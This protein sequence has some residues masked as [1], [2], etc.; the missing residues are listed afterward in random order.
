VKIFVFAVNS[1]KHFSTLCARF[2]LELEEEN[3]WKFRGNLCRLQPFA[4][5]VMLKPSFDFFKKPL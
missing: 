4:A 3:T 1:K 5:S 2:S